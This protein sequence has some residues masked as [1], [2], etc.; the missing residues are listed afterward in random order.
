MED[1]PNGYDGRHGAEMQRGVVVIA[2]K[3]PQVYCIV[4]GLGEKSGQGIVSMASPP[5]AFQWRTFCPT[6]CIEKSIAMKTLILIIFV[7]S[8]SYATAQDIAKSDVPT[9]VSAALI[10][11]GQGFQ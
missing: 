9:E 5:C 2:A 7:G 3:S 8:I 4:E 1:H 6:K 10:V 11:P